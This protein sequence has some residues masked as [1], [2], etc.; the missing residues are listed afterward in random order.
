MECATRDEQDVTKSLIYPFTSHSDE[1]STDRHISSH[2]RHG[3][4]YKRNHA[5]VSCVSEQHAQWT[6]LIECTADANEQRCTNRTTNSDELDLAISK[7]SLEVIRVIS[8]R[9]MLDVIRAVV[10]LANEFAGVLFLRGSHGCKGSGRTGRVAWGWSR[11]R[12]WRFGN[13]QCRVRCVGCVALDV[14]QGGRLK[15]KEKE[16]EL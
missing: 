5:G 7:M 4:V 12:N 3:V 1:T 14:A 8:H 9:T 6:A 15:P 11:L 16:P 10:R 2:L 13:E